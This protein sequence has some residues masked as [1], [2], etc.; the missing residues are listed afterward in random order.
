MSKK[1]KFILSFI[2]I[3]ILVCLFFVGNIAQVIINI[4]WFN[5]M[6]Y[7]SVYFTK[8]L[9]VLK[10]MVPVFILSYI[11][12]LL[13][14][15][16]IKKSIAHMK[17]VV[18]V[19]TKKDVIENKIFIASNLFISLLFSF[20][21]S[22]T[23]WYMLLQ[24]INAVNFNVKDPIFNL[25]V[26]FYIFKLPLIQSL[27]SFIMTLLV[28]LII[29]KVMV[30]FVFKTKNTFNAGKKANPFEDIKS[31]FKELS[32]F[33][34]KQIAIIAS[35]I[36]F[37]LSLGYLLNSFNL[38]YSPSG[39]A[40]GASYTDIHVTLLFYKILIRSEEHTSELQSQ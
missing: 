14:Y 22:S 26:S 33:A 32:V 27:Y 36:A 19:N 8:I 30:F 23:Y 9:T 24:F 7:I 17:K 16:G 13:Y 6:G 10:L 34:G 37:F 20:A 40:Y 15:K 39:V 38:V 11:G 3:I 21:F 29:I 4:E 18:E 31:T 35:L 12:I 5:T 28:L 2:I 1:K 25:D